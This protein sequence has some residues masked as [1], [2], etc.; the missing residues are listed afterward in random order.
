LTV[1]NAVSLEV[2]PLEIVAVLGNNGAGKSTLLRTISGLL[3][4]TRGEIYW[5]G[6]RIDRLPP[7]QILRRGLAHVPEERRIFSD[8]TVEENLKIGAL[9]SPSA[10]V[11]KITIDQIYSDFPLLAARRKQLGNTLSGGEQQ[12]LAICRGLMSKPKCLLLDEPS[13]GLSPLKAQEVFGAIHKIRERGVT[14]LLVEQNCFAALALADRGVV[15]ETGR[16]ALSGSAAALSENPHVQRTYLG[17]GD[18]N[19]VELPK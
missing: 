19:Q 17:L 8:L 7:H 11:L 1:V 5:E 13:L 15:L 16:L 2:N 10:S 12:I 3:R 18:V 6:E 9:F 14:I 4:P